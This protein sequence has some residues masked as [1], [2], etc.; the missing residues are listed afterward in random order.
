MEE[1]GK[2]DLDIKGLVMT[3]K[4]ATTLHFSLQPPLYIKCGF[5]VLCI[6]RRNL[7][8]TP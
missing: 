6:N 1:S 8:P 5:A 4:M 7:F 3:E 2:R